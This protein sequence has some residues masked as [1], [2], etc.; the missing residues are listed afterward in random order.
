MRDFLLDEGGFRSSTLAQA[1]KFSLSEIGLVAQAKASSPI[2]HNAVCVRCL[3]SL[4]R[5][6]DKGMLC[7]ERVGSWMMVNM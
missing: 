4:M 5:N 2:E 7:H 3:Y 6:L 1:K